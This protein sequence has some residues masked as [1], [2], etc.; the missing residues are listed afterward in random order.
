MAEV[1]KETDERPENDTEEI[2]IVEEK[3]QEQENED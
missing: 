3:P 2:V 1:M